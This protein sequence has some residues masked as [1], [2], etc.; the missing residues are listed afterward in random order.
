VTDPRML[1]D[2]VDQVSYLAMLEN[3]VEGEAIV[4]TEPAPF[5]RQSPIEKMM[6]MDKDESATLSAVITGRVQ[7][8]ED[9]V[10][11]DAIIPA[12]HMPVHL[13]HLE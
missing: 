6:K 4:Y 5:I 11:T 13:F 2:A 12:E 10:D 8:F 9:H 1:L 3:P 7:R